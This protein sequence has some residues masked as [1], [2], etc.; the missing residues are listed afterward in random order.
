[1]KAELRRKQKTMEDREFSLN[2]RIQRLNDE[3]RSLQRTTEEL[4]LVQASS[5]PG[6]QERRQACS[7]DWLGSEPSGLAGDEGGGTPRTP[8]LPGESAFPK[9]GGPAGEGG[10]ASPV[11]RLK[12]PRAHGSSCVVGPPQ[13]QQLRELPV[14]APPPA[15]KHSW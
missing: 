12:I 1:M 9:E 2:E 4:Q 15:P 8:A 14:S 11:L 5:G 10:G 13:S 3:F 6:A 7:V